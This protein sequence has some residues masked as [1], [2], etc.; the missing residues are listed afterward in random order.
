MN[1]TTNAATLPTLTLCEVAD[2][3]PTHESPSPFCIKVHRALKARGLSYQRRHAPVPAAHGALN[4]AGQVPI[5][6][7]GDEAVSD[8]TRILARIDE[9]APDPAGPLPARQRAEAL[10]WEELADTAVNGYVVAARWADERNWPGVEQA[11]FG[12]IP[13]QARADVSG[14]IR[15]HIVDGLRRDLWR[16]GAEACWARFTALLDQLEERAPEA[17]FWVSDRLSA[18]DFGLFGQLH[19]LRM[20]L[21][22]WQMEQIAARPRL[23]AYLDR[24]DA[25]TRR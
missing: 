18:A 10:L 7:V 20:P 17:G 19:S 25:A 13:A 21:T 23:T 9:I 3:G 6:L 4:P 2:L 14:K 11:Y 16:L 15:G 8:S 24:V 5:L 22:A 12:G 1:T